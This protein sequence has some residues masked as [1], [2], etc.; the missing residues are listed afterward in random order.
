MTPGL[1][2]VPSGGSGVVYYVSHKSSLNIKQRSYITH[3]I[4]IVAV[5]WMGLVIDGVNK[6]NNI[7]N[8]GVDE[9]DDYN[10]HVDENN[11]A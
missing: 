3:D 2:S 9:D 6:G 7:D 8:G 4:V 10:D 11:D 5:S 1:V